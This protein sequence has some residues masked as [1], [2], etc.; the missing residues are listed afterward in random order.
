MNKLKRFAYIIEF[1]IGFAPSLLL[2]IL[3]VVF[4]PVIFVGLFSGELTVLLYTTLVL[5]GLCGFWGAISLLVLTLHPEQENTKPKR[6]KVYVALG[7][8]SSAIVSYSVGGTNIYLLPFIIAPL[9]VTLH[10]VYVQR[11]YL[12]GSTANTYEP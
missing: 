11:R 5:F 4:S 8:I 2:L 6:L 7:V 3:C 12:A 1:M 10:L 9:F